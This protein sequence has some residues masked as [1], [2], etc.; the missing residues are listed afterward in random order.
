[1]GPIGALIDALGSCG[2]E[3]MPHDWDDWKEWKKWKGRHRHGRPDWSRPGRVHGSDRREERREERRA[4]RAERAERWTEELEAERARRR[5]R[6]RRPELTPEEE[7]YREARRAAEHKIRFFQH[8]VS[9][10]FVI[11]FLLFVTRSAFV[12]TVVGLG[13][14]IGLASHFFQVI[15]APNL[16]QKWV[17]DEVQRQ[18]ARSVSRQ[19][20]VL[21][22]EKLR[23]LEELSASI[24]HE[25]RNPITAA[26]SLVQQLGEDPTS[27][28][29]VEYANIALQELDRVEKSISHL[30]RYARE[31][32]MHP[33]QMKLVD[34][35]ESALETL[36]ERLQAAN[37]KIRRDFDS[38]G[39]LIGDREQL[40]RVFINVIGN[41]LDA[42]TE[43]K[44]P[45]PQL[46]IGVGENLG[47]SEIWARVRDNGPGM[48]AETQAR[49]FKPFFTSKAN[50]TG[51]GLAITRKLVDAHG[52]TIEVSS[53]PGQGSEFTIQFP[54]QAQSP[55]ART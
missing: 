50:G 11:L 2:V 26:K 30:L 23:S 54:K 20:V 32:E 45:S 19:R 25:I 34:A 55:E 52:G 37:V 12:A 18:V 41:A 14:G 13:W 9:Y 15:V 46:A 53:A 21:E 1:M 39:E 43:A 22:D 49:I 40:R 6:H 17:R 51:L 29:N 38:Q 47:G 5:E 10:T 42:F 36:R 33:Q 35:V 7:A 24:A 44:T 28:E 48:D 3:H 16:R 31:E 27:S 4:E 8:L